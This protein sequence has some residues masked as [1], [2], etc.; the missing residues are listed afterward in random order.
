[1][2]SILL[3][4]KVV[5][6][7][8]AILA[9]LLTWSTPAAAQ[10][11]QGT[12][13]D[14][15]KKESVGF[16]VD[17]ENPAEEVLAI[18]KSV[19]SDKTIRGSKISTKDQAMEIDDAEFASSSKVFGPLPSSGQVFYKVKSDAIAPIHFPG[20]NGSGT[21]VVRYFVHPLAAE[22]TR[23]LIDAVFFQDALRARYFSDGSVEAAE[24]GEILTQLKALGSPKSPDNHS[25]QSPAVE[26]D[27]A[28]LQN[29]LAA[30]QARLAEANAAAQELEK[31]I[32]R[33]RF[34]T[35]G[36]VRTGGV[37]LK[38]LPYNHSPTILTLEKGEGVTVLAT[39]KYWY[40]VRTPKGEEGWVYYEFLGPLS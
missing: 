39:S 4:P 24:Y 33:L 18:V 20:S 9:G 13:H 19:A 40:R 28:G 21:V 5:W 26:A 2:R 23:L 37:P 34:N 35:E 14:P 30:L 10:A 17:L 25:A 22:R 38:V 27:S 16:S 29:T 1:M 3:Y 8:P 15:R 11:F 32:E 31:R 12:F 6:W 36:Q 7:L